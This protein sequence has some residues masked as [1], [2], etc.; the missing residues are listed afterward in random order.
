MENGA[1]AVKEQMLHSFK[2]MIFHGRQK[3]LLW[4]KGLTYMHSYLVGLEV[5]S[6]ALYLHLHFYFVS[7]SS[8]GSGVI[9]HMH[10]LI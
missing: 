9:D 3:T 8:K 7:V 1:F 10:R 5:I 6:F 2:Y 4:S